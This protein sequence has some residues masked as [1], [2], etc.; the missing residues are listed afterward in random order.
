M[1]DG[2]AGRWPLVLELWPSK[3]CQNGEGSSLFF[4]QI[5]S[6]TSEPRLA[7]RLIVGPG[8]R[9]VH[10]KEVYGMEEGG[11]CI[12]CMTNERNTMVG[13]LKELAALE[14]DAPFNMIGRASTPSE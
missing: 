6:N 12:I 5:N 3:S 9:T 4:F 11:T 10:L 7:E 14:S 1:A 2:K 13:S 8:G